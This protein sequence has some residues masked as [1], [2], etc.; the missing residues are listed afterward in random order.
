MNNPR[1]NIQ[2]PQA[3]PRTTMGQVYSPLVLEAGE[4]VKGSQTVFDEYYNTF[5][6]VRKF[7]AGEYDESKTNYVSSTLTDLL[8]STGAG[9][10]QSMKQNKP[11][12]ETLGTNYEQFVDKQ[13]TKTGSRIAG[14]LVTEGGI[15][16]A[17]IGIGAGVG[18]ATRGFKSLG[19]IS[20]FFSS[21]LQPTVP[22]MKPRPKPP[23]DVF[24]F[25]TA[26]G[27]DSK[28]VG[29]GRGISKLGNKQKK[30]VESA[31]SGDKSVVDD[32]NKSITDMEKKSSRRFWRSFEEPKVEKGDKLI[33][34]KGT[35]QIQK[36]KPQT[37]TKQQTNISGW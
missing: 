9:L 23:S 12:W 26:L 28:S 21:S 24:K 3:R 25:D 27:M 4:F 20:K 30:K 37:K 31:L 36:Q 19:G 10:E 13:K 7:F 5:N 32:F 18:L 35:Q 14:E 22:T 16:L 2:Q 17:T 33:G 15:M 8:Y 6:D 29:L 1:Q 11:L 34:T